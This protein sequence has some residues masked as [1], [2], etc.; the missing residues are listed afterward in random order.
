MINGSGNRTIE[1]SDQKGGPVEDNPMT[2]SPMLYSSP[3]Y[4]SIVMGMKSRMAVSLVLLALFVSGFA[5]AQSQAS[6][7]KNDPLSLVGIA[8]DIAS[9]SQQHNLDGYIAIYVSPEK[10]AVA[11]KDGD[12]GP[13]LKLKEAKP[14]RSA[15]FFFSAAAPSKDLAIGVY[16]DGGTAFGVTAAQ[17]GASGKIEA[18]DISAGY[19]AVTKEMLKNASQGFR[20]GQ[21][22]INTDDGEPLTAYAITK[23]PA[24]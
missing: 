3:A 5:A 16:F 21:V 15:V 7:E 20:F 19:K 6:P 8:V 9:N 22:E 24:N 13:F 10:W 11:L 1:S 18:G 23:K 12:L 14:G 4:S 2:D 17:A